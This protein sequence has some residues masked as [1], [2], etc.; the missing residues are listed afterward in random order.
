M[1]VTVTRTAKTIFIKYGCTLLLA[2]CS[3]C[4][5]G[6]V[7][8]FLL[9][10]WW[11]LFEHGIRLL[12]L[13]GILN[14]YSGFFISIGAKNIGVPLLLEH[15]CRIL[16]QIIKIFENPAVILDEKEPILAHPADILE[17]RP[18]IRT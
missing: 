10:Q 13:R 14:T 9:E 12:E 16:E 6:R 4:L 18:F 11:H 2:E 15:W 17:N 1:H 5:S 3:F 8:V 7:G